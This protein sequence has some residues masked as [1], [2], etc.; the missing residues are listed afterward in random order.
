LI[1]IRDCKEKDIE[2]VVSRRK[3]FSN[4]HTSI[5]PDYYSFSDNSL[6]EFQDYVK[7]RLNDS[8]FK[9]L[10]AEENDMCIGY[11]MGWIEYRPPIYKKRKVGYLSNIFIDPDYQKQ[12]TGTQLYSRIETWFIEKKVDLIEIKS[13]IK[14]E[15][16][17]HAFLAYGFKK[18]SITFYKD[19]Y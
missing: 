17:I 15:K 14:N 2:V 1:L 19:P 10:I 7:K 16:A 12:K 3:V 4:M 11:V 13:D 5:N 8:D 18:I 9:L 6:I